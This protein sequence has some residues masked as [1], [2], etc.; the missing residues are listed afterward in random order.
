MAHARRAFAE[1]AKLSKKTGLAAEALKFFQKL[2]AIEK[3]ARENQYTPQA[4]HE[5]RKKNAPPILN[6]F[7]K[8]LEHHLPKVPH[9]HK[10]AQAIQ[11]TLKNWTE[12]NN[13]L[14]DGR[15][16]IDNNLIEN[17]IRPFAIGRKN[18]LFHG[19]PAGAKAGTI[20]YSLIETCKINQIE[21]YK[22]FCNMLNKIR[23][24]KSD[25]DYRKLLP[26]FIQF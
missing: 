5:L 13:Y 12:L 20:L 19:S 4:R 16:E 17:A 14:K 9:Q 22:Y 23:L 24:C 18:W 7:K 26:Q 8:W 6:V 2:Y 15:I 11:Y 25:D 21:P 1:L 3:Q 10:I